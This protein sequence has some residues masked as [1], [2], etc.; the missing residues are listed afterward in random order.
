MEEGEVYTRLAEKVLF[1]KSRFI[2]MVFRKLVTPEEGEMLL[3]LPATPEEFAEKYHMDVAAAA[4]KLDEFAR[5]GVSIPLEKGGIQRYFCVS[6]I[7]QVH[8]ATIHGAMNKRYENP[9]MEIIEWWKRFRET[10]WFEILRDMEGQG[11]LRG[12]AV[13]SWSTVKDHPELQPYENL[14]EILKQA[15]GI[16]AVDCPCRWLQVQHGECDKPTFVCLSLTHGSVKY[17]VDQGIGKTLTLEEGYALLEQCEKAG[18]IPTTSGA[19][20]VKQLCFCETKECIVLRP[21][22]QYGYKL[23]EPSRFAAAVNESLCIG[24]ET[25]VKRCPFTAIAAEAVPDREKPLARV[26]RERCFGCGVCA[27]TCPTQAL[28]MEL[29]RPLEH[30]IGKAAASD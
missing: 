30:I 1:P 27:V 21:Q 23:W 8:D 18:L 22:V 12:R 19:E 16:A 15:P 17:I 26:D 29:V 10:E 9:P 5:K 25:C 2:K 20:K 7:I 14:R 6:N 24:C 28:R 4:K 3:S 11:I 13:P